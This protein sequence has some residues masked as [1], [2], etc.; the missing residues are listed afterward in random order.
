MSALELAPAPRGARAARGA[1]ARPRRRRAARRDT[2]R[3]RARARAL[4][5][6]CRGFLAPGDLLVVNTSATLPAALAAQLGGRSRRAARSRR[7]L[8]R[9][10]LGRRAANRA[11][12]AVPAPAGRRARSSFPDGAHAELLAPYAGSDR[13]C[14]ARLA[15]G[16]TARA[17]TSRRHG[18]PIRYGYVPERV[19][20]RRLPDGLRARARQR[21]DAE[22]RPAV[23]APSSS[24]RSSRAASCVAPVDAAHRR[25]VA[26]ARRAAVPR[27]VPRARRRRRGS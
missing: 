20:D 9:R 12:D 22:R 18:R 3:R 14:V 16:A 26:R 23:H 24:P 2:A 11:G 15:L 17:T 10:R 6:S 21:R 8:R 13:L 4:P 19:A 25:L 27:A 5:T 1:R 7:R